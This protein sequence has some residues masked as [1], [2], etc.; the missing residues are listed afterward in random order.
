METTSYE[1]G[2][3]VVVIR[4]D[5]CGREIAQPRQA[6]GDWFRV[7]VNRLARDAWAEEDPL[8]E[9][10]F[11]SPDCLRETLADLDPGDE[12]RDRG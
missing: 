10:D 11:C 5:G 8:A 4:C 12:E 1:D 3:N 6:E 7:R 9:L 2:Y